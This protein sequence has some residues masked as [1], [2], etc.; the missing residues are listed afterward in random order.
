M[1]VKTFWD[2]LISKQLGIQGVRVACAGEIVGRPAGPGPCGAPR[3]TPSS[4][5][6]LQKRWCSPSEFFFFL[7]AVLCI[8]TVIIILIWWYC[9]CYHHH[10]YCLFSLYHMWR[11]ILILQL[12]HH[13]CTM[14]HL[15]HQS[16]LS[17]L[18]ILC[19]CSCVNVNSLDCT[20]LKIN[21]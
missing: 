20:N 6:G 15:Q 9:L 10:H 4:L 18:S 16:L 2:T 17:L 21:K 7:V 11:F 14:H 8:I 5:L 3:F 1:I 13:I 19:L 12:L